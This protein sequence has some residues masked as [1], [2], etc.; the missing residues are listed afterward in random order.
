MDEFQKRENMLAEHN[1]P[2]NN[3]QSL[4]D[5]N[6]ILAQKGI[7]FSAE[8]FNLISFSF[9]ILKIVVF[10]ENEINEMKKELMVLRKKFVNQQKKFPIFLC[11]YRLIQLDGISVSD[12]SIKYTGIF[13]INNYY[14]SKY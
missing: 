4:P 10:S 1:L 7:Y 14:L 5:I 12:N 11:S 6:G 9:L 8:R 3:E 2:T 13:W